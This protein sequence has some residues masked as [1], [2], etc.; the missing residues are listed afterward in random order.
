[1]GTLSNILF[2]RGRD[3]SDD[4]PVIRQALRGEQET[5]I[6]LILSAAPGSMADL[7]VAEFLRLATIYSAP[8]GGIWVAETGQRLLEAVLPVVSPGK[9]MLLFFSRRLPTPAAAAQVIDAVC[10]HASAGGITLAQALLDPA[11]RDARTFLQSVGFAEL[12]Q[13]LYL[14]IILNAPR[15]MPSLA[16]NQQWITYSPKTHARFAQTILRAYEQSLDCPALNGMREIDDIIAGHQATGK[17]DPNLWFV[18]D[19]DG[20]D[21]AV[22]LLAPLDNSHVMELVYLGVAPEARG[23]KLG[24]LLMRQA[25][26][27][28]SLH[29]K[30]ALSLAVD[31]RNKPALNLYWRHGLA[32][33][34]QKIALLRDLRPGAKPHSRA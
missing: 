34:G 22:L 8:A 31:A 11:N 10:D 23:K 1:L 2:G 14:Q 5:A 28:V 17:F 24:D 33:V 25:L 19:E 26:A 21:L 29:D 6:R 13:L 20:K 9:T 27:C 12:A 18:L 4:K 7:Q 16:A 15:P 3:E 30:S 32:Q